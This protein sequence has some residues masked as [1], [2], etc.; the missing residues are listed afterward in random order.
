MKDAFVS[1]QK[2]GSVSLSKALWRAENTSML[3]HGYCYRV[4]PSG[5]GWKKDRFDDEFPPFDAGEYDHLYA[6]VRNPFDILVSYYHHNDVWPNHW[7]GWLNCNR[8]GGFF[9]W[10]Q[11]LEA[12]IDP[13]H[14]WHLPPMKTS[15]FSFA[16]DEQFE[17]IIDG[18]WKLE[19]VKLLNELLI[20]RGGAKLQHLNVNTYDKTLKFYTK[21]EVLKL[22]HIWRRDL[23]H[24]RYGV[25]TDYDPTR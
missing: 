5:Q 16:Y 9:S 11:F 8:R 2:A 18:F 12:Y 14:R 24:F 6:L 13:G 3:E 17:L 7:G 4:G 10:E 1:I 21:S 25:P 22:K 15:M 23:A 20:A 19:N